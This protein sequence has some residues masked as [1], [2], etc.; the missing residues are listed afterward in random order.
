MGASLSR[1]VN[2]FHALS[3][4]QGCWRNTKWMGVTT[5]KIPND[6]WLYQEIIVEVQPDL[7]IETGTYMGGSALFMAHILEMIGKGRI[8]TIDINR[9][10]NP[11]EHKRLDYIRGSSTAS[12]TV[13]KI[14]KMVGSLQ[15]VLVILDSSHL[16]AHVLREMEIYSEMVSKNSYLIVEDSNVNGHPIIPGYRET[17]G[18]EPG[19][20]MEAIDAFMAVN[21]NFEIDIQRHRYLMTFN[22][23][24]YLRRTA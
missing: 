12:D 4:A 3:Y 18:D 11:P 10:E 24:G 9:P 13:K 15:T 21:N 17:V 5:Y 22:P 6:L 14:E 8:V 7:I 19:G 1:I 2:E 23:R 20:P 16:T